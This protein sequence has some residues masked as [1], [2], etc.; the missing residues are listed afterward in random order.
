MADKTAEEFA[1]EALKRGAVDTIGNQARKMAVSDRIW[2]AIVR[3]YPDGKRSVMVR[4]ARFAATMDP[5]I[6]EKETHVL[7]MYPFFEHRAASEFAEKLKN[8]ELGAY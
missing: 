7:K 4:R 6:E 3:E 1:I 8:N 5:I 2:A